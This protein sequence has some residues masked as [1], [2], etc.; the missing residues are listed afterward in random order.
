M[1]LRIAAGAPGDRPSASTAAI[2]LHRFTTFYPGFVAAAL[3]TNDG[4][5]IARSD[6]R[7]P[8]GR[9]L[10]ID[11]IADATEALGLVSFNDDRVS[12][13]LE[14]GPC[15]AIIAATVEC[16]TGRAKCGLLLCCTR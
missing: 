13:V 15:E 16:P 10:P 1:P 12:N 3:V 2:R 8:N 9:T 5:I 14:A 4:R 11:G 6:L 7:D